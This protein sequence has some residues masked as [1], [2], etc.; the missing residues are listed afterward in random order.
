MYK[1]Q[2]LNITGAIAAANTLGVPMADLI[3]QVRQLESVPHRLQLIRGGSSLIIDDAYNSNPSGAKAALDT[4]SQ[5]D[6]VKILVTPGMV[7]LG[8]RQE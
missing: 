2:V 4:L 1:R 3:P 7:E 8:A 5:F 6:G